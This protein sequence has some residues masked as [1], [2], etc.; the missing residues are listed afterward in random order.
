MKIKKIRIKNFKS[1]KDTGD[2]IIN[3][4]LYVLAGQNESGKSSIFEALNCFEE[5][6]FSRDN[7]NFELEQSNNLIQEVKITYESLDND[8]L[9]DCTNELTKLVKQKNVNL[10]FDELPEVVDINKLSHIKS[11][12]ITKKSDFNKDESNLIVEIDEN[13]M[14]IVLSAIN[15]FYSKNIKSNI[16]IKKEL[17]TTEKNK[18]DIAEIFWKNSPNIIFFKD[19]QSLLPDKIL[20][21]VIGDENV[22][23]SKAVQ[24]L[25][26][27][28]DM[29]FLEISKKSIAQKNS[30]ASTE[31]LKVSSTFQKDWNQR[32]F[33]DNEVNI[34]FFI[35]KNAQG[36]DEVSFFVETKRDELL[37]PRKRSQGMIWFLSLWLELK[38]NENFKNLILLFDEPGLY[39]HIKAN[40]DMVSLFKKLVAKGHQ[41]IYSTHSPS[42]IDTDILSNIGLVYNDKKY[43]TRT[44][45]LTSSRFNSKNKMDALYPISEAMGMEPLRDFSAFKQKNVLVEGLSDFWILKGFKEILK[46]K[47]NYEFIPCIGIKQN[48]ISPLISFCIGYGLEWLLVMDGGEIPKKTKDDL[49]K[50]L[51]LESDDKIFLL[52]EKEIENM[53]HFNDLLQVNSNYKQ[54]NNSKPYNVIGKKRKII[55][56]KQFYNQVKSGKL[57]KT[58]IE[59]STIEKF[60]II[61]DWIDKQFI[62]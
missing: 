30:K 45:G 29:K 34:R 8:F 22:K 56:S 10:S 5:D 33:T 38:A 50:C 48:K 18:K 6:K 42:L 35:E 47:E 17:L 51:N 2:I 32:L 58:S 60:Q 19:F 54:N 20:I 57:K 53:F 26:S 28:L 40:R 12:T 16:K 13:A 44:E 37:P 55:F 11:F 52:P 62:K 31:S 1:I 9:N 49:I 15:S 3:D 61:F 24:N 59:N 27:L 25:E 21:N 41:I 4:D 7:I 46:V 14:K 23:G 36:S 39:L 43:G